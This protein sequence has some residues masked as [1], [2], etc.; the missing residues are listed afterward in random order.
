MTAETTD[1]GAARATRREW[2]G[3]AVLAL[4]T[5]LLSL[6]MS[7][8][9]LALP[10]LSADLGA[11]AP[12]Q[13]WIM[14]I[15]GFMIAG[16]LVT[17]GTLGDRIGR[18][19]LLMIGGTAFAVASVLAA[20]SASP[21]M[22]IATRA[23]LGVA[24]ATLMPSTL[25]LISTMFRDAHQRAVAIAVWMTC[26]MGGMT[27]GPLVGGAL[28]EHF[29]WGSAFLLGVP[30]MVLLLV[31]AP[32]LLPEYRDAGAG[33]L[34]LVSV[35]LSLAAI[36]PVIYGVKELAHGG[37][38]A[39][40]VAALVAGAA[41]GLVFVRRQARLADPLLDLSLFANRRF[42]T[43]L[44]ANLGGG[45]VMAGTFLLFS[46]FLQMVQGLSPLRAGLWLVPVNV[47]MAVASMLAPQLA[48]R[49]RPGYVMAGGFAVAAAGLVLVTRADAA[50][51][52]GMVVTGFALASVGVALPS[53]LL[54]DLVVGS[55]PPD[56]A[57]AAS[58]LSETSGELG[59][60]LGVAVLGSVAATIY[61]DQVVVPAGLPAEAAGVA[62]ESI[63][64]A[65]AVAGRLPIEVGAAL[66]GPAREAFTAGL[67]V[68]AGVGA[69]LFG[70]MALL[71]AVTFRH[72]RPTAA[73]PQ[74]APSASEA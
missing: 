1:P 56:K 4:P 8:L 57:G 45:V 19:R 40:P 38:Q 53:A 32:V 37:W 23:L 52:L 43:A 28:L 54:I 51:G 73:A 14:D 64:G 10:Y 12:Q 68:A 47:A 24:G 66:L 48:R 6:D 46:Q 44:G 59:I 26:F 20:Y 63:A 58:G 50:D 65:V 15:Y 49:L 9:Y 34:D 21:E 17:M 5:L 18:R 33:R 67:T 2:T 74:P 27:V 35:V 22:L 71:V 3:L 61:R 39:G 60:A 13:L 62:G 36:L 41:F 72:L 31:T 70:G 55:A 7:V 11:T 25:S 42:S 16:F 69:V 29:W 30:V